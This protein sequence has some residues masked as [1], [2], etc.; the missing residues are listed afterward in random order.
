MWNIED[1]TK[2]QNYEDSKFLSKLRISIHNLH[3]K[4]FYT[5]SAKYLRTITQDITLF[6]RQISSNKPNHLCEKLRDTNTVRALD[7][8]PRHFMECL[9]TG[10]GVI[11]QLFA[12]KYYLIGYKY[13]ASLHICWPVCSGCQVLIEGHRPAKCTHCNVHFLAHNQHTSVISGTI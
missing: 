12:I 1:T 13:Q 8:S 4:P 7:Y 9:R 6:T 11:S 2:I 3:K 5:S 10:L